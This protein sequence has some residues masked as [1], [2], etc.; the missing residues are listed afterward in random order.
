MMAALVLERGGRMC[1]QGFSEGAKGLWEWG[2][3]VVEWWCSG[4]VV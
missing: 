4:V 3:G 1:Y 2:V